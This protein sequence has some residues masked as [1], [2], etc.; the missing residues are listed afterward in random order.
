MKRKLQLRRETLQP[1]GAQTLELAYGGS[2]TVPIK[3]T[4][5]RPSDACGTPT[6]TR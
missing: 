2:L 6:A 4:I 1:L 5:V 3:D